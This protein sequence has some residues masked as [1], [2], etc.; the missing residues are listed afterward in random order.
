VI[1]LY[2]GLILLSATAAALGCLV[3]ARR[4]AFSRGARI[5]WALVGFLF[6]WA[7]FVLLLVYQE[8]PARVS[9]PHCRKLRIASR[10]QCEHCGALHATPAPGGTEIVE[11]TAPV[12]ACAPEM[13][14]H[15]DV[16]AL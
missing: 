14:E 7:G 4:Y 13:C 6:G 16:I 3:L 1:C 5:G 9:C 8:W 10:E 15:G 12:R 2:L 11:A